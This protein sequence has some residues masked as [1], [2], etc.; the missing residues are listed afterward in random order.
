MT[1]SALPLGR[2]VG[3]NDWEQ[4]VRADPRVHTVQMLVLLTA[5]TYASPDGSDVFPSAKTLGENTRLGESTVRRHLAAG[6][7]LGFLHLVQRGGRDLQ[8]GQGT[9]RSNRY[10]LTVPAEVPT[11]SPA[12]VGVDPTAPQR[13]DGVPTEGPTAP[14]RADEVVPTARLE[15]PNRS[16]GSADHYIKTNHQDQDQEHVVANPSKFSSRPVGGGGSDGEKINLQ[17]RQVAEFFDA[18]PEALG[19]SRTDSVRSAVKAA[20]LRGWDPA[21]LARRIGGHDYTGATNRG[22]VAVRFLAELAERGPVRAGG[23]VDSAAPRRPEWCGECNE[24]TRRIED[25]DQNDVGKCPRCHADRAALAMS[26]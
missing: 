6:C 18:L 13:A 11:A 17:D 3:R 5:S 9:G 22:A 10:V 8:K 26:A 4:A 2:R 7:R 20:C 23:S 12:A 25:E 24:R 14:Q 15:G 21:A 16:L 1:P 19:V